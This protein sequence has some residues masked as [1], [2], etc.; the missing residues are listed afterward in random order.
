MKVRFFFIALYNLQKYHESLFLPFD[1]ISGGLSAP[2]RISDLLSSHFS[3]KN[4][5]SQKQHSYCCAFHPC[6][7]SHNHL[8]LKVAVVSH[9][10][11]SFRWHA[12]GF[13]AKVWRRQQAMCSSVRRTKAPPMSTT[14]MTV[15]QRCSGRFWYEDV[16]QCGRPVVPRVFFWLSFWISKEG[17]LRGRAHS[18]RSHLI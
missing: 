9:L 2:S 6:F 17:T 11:G 12:P 3:Q 16:L 8:M 13:V 18:T 14:A 15:H 1:V 4:S 5:W 10:W 7:T